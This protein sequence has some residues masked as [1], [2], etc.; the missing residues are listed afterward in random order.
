MSIRDLKGLGEK[1]EMML[2]KI[3]ISSTEDFLKADPFEMY[4]RLK[5]KFSGVGVNFL[6]AIIGAQENVSWIEIAKTRRTEILLTLDDMGIA[7]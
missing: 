2:E 3:G 6:Y 5:N 1:S 4:A 7:P